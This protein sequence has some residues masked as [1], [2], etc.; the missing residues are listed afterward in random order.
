MLLRRTSIA[1]GAVIGAAGIATG[2]FTFA[3]SGTTVTTTKSAG[4]A[5]A[6]TNVGGSSVGGAL[7]VPAQGDDGSSGQ[8][9]GGSSAQGSGGSAG[10]LSAPAPNQVPLAGTNGS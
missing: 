10:G 2:L 1:T 4:A 7:T 3:V 8:V 5:P 6:A 9:F